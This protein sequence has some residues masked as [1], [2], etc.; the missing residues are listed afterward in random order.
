MENNIPLASSMH[1]FLSP[2]LAEAYNDLSKSLQKA[3]KG[4]ALL[5][6]IP[7]LKDR[8]VPIIHVPKL[9]RYKSGYY[10]LRKL[11]RSQRKY[12]VK[13]YKN[14]HRYIPI[15]NWLESSFTDMEEFLYTFYW[16]ESIKGFDYWDNIAIRARWATK[17]YVLPMEETVYNDLD[18]E[19]KISINKLSYGIYNRDSSN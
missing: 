17:Q 1:E 9:D 6:D 13:E 14:Y 16:E 10:Y 5:A 15:V 7:M 2:E 19:F 3:T 12:W 18:T 4:V 11:T 8:L